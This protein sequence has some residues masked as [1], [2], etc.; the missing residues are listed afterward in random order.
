MT[1]RSCCVH[2]PKNP[3]CFHRLRISFFF[4][5]TRSSFPCLRLAVSYKSGL[6]CAQLTFSVPQFSLRRS[7]YSLLPTS[8]IVFAS[9]SLFFRRLALRFHA[10]EWQLATSP[11]GS[12]PSYHFPFHNSIFA[13]LSTLYF[14]RPSSSSH[15][16]L[17]FPSTRSSC[18][19]L[20]VALSYKPGRICAQLPLSAPRFHPRRSLYS[21]IP[22]IFHR[23]RISL[24]FSSTLSPITASFRRPFHRY[25]NDLSF[26][27]A[28]GSS[29]ELPSPV[30][31]FYWRT[32][33]RYLRQQPQTTQMP[34]PSS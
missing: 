5:S 25:I 34:L 30:H 4:S 32:K 15:L 1:R 33:S 7:L 10:F 20:R 31:A 9:R 23:L 24:Y 12:A 21:L 2:N 11:A 3:S 19:C 6:I 26:S 27:C 17:F 22:Q 16:A 28:V 13:D 29:Q 18:P 8:Y 14:R